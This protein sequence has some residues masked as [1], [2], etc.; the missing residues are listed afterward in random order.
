MENTNI[1]QIHTTT[2]NNKD[3]R[4]YKEERFKKIIQHSS[5]NK[6]AKDILISIVK[7]R[8]RKTI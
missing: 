4:I 5:E 1:Q 7:I 6:K 2:T 3:L 8:V